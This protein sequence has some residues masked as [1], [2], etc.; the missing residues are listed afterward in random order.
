MLINLF[1]IK[2]FFSI[3]VLDQTCDTKILGNT[4]HSIRTSNTL[5]N[6]AHHFPFPIPGAD[7]PRIEWVIQRRRADGVPVAPGAAGLEHQAV[8]GRVPNVS[9]R[10]AF[11]SDR[12][13][14]RSTGGQQGAHMNWPPAAAAAAAALAAAVLASSSVALLQELPPTASPRPGVYC[15]QN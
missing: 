2:L 3:H 11:P 13:T 10:L 8:A 9:S 1:L 5:R 15:V 14:W 12:R 4:I 7:A 6:Q